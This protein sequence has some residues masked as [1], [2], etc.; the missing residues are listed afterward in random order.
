[1]IANYGVGVDNIDLDAAT[2]RGVLVSN[3]PDVLT[4]AT[5]DIAFALILA[6]ARRVVEGD[7]R[8]REGKFKYWAPLHFLGREI[9][10]KTLGIM[11]MG[12][13]GTAVARRARGFEMEILY[14]NRRKIE[15]AD[16]EALG[17]QYV[18]KETLLSE[19]DFIS[20]HVPLTDQTVHLIGHEEL[21]LM[22]P[23]AYLIN[24]SR[25]AVVHERA[26]VE[27]L[28][29]NRIAGAGLDVY[30]NEPE[31]APGLGT[32]D[33]AVLLP[34]MGSATQE[35]RTK[36]GQCAADNLLAGL[37]GEI[38]PNCLNWDALHK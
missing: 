25:G 38:P 4:D 16:E 13:I 19:S 24:T 34:H 18:S 11:G 9:T 31:M 37:R 27:A 1:M 10:G 20:L 2:K 7:K 8:N 6:V 21:K 22:K 3:T 29:G 26:L 17:A 23:T 30:E 12:R 5:A 35:T 32:L 15:R 36:M 28:K 33:N 14:H